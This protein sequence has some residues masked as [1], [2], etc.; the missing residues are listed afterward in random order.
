MLKKA[1]SKTTLIILSIIMLS[2]MIMG[3]CS[4][5]T[6]SK[7]SGGTP[8][9]LNGTWRYIAVDIESQYLHIDLKLNNGNSES[10]VKSLIYAS[11]Y[12]YDGPASRGTYSTNDNQFT[13]VA[14]GFYGGYYS[15]WG[16]FFTAKWYTVDEF[17][18]T[19][20]DYYRS[21]GYSE[22]NI[23]NSISWI[24]QP[25]TTTYSLNGNT[26]VIGETIYTKI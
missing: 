22:E 25:S 6:K 13:S 8:S 11:G 14:T 4:K 2:L 15:N 10:S 1:K 26:L 18:N 16:G 17:R 24:G 3:G 23:N 9:H 5:T 7:A 20:R 12:V 21:L 19:M